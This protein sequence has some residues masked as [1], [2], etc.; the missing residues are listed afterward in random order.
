MFTTKFVN[1]LVFLNSN[2]EKSSAT[3]QFNGF[4]ASSFTMP[5][6]KPEN[7]K[8][9]NICESLEKALHDFDKAQKAKMALQNEATHKNKPELEETFKKLKQ[10]IT[11]LS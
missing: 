11:E 6:A 9:K 4:Q 1:P 10:L 3:W 8:L 5:K 7:I 2:A